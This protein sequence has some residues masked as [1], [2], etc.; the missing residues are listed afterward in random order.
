[1]STVRTICT[2][3]LRRIGIVSAVDSPSAEDAAAALAHLNEM[4]YGWAADGVDVLQQADW[5]LDDEFVFWVPP[6]DADA[7]TIAALSYR[8]TWDAT[9]NSPTLTSSSGTEGYVYKVATAG[10]TTLDDVTSW[11]LNDYAVFNR[12]EWLKGINSRR[13]DAGVVAMLAVRC[14]AEFGVEASG[15]TTL[16]A[17][18]TWSLMLPYYVKPPLATFDLALR[19]IPSRNGVSFDEELSS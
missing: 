19:D 17:R 16:L 1:M 2:R 11:A 14:A 4:T 6:L 8:G 10:S 9:A 3:A 13:F 18:Q 12:T 15:E 5:T 7:G